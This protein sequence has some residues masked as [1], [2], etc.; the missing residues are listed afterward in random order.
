[1]LVERELVST[2]SLN[3]SIL[4]DRRDF[5]PSRGIFGPI[6]VLYALLVIRSLFG[7]A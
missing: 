2:K 6:I 7:L 4:G 1:M 3:R 5:R